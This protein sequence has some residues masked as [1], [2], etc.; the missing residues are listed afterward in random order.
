MSFLVSCSSPVDLSQ[1][2]TAAQQGSSPGPRKTFTRTRISVHA[3][4]V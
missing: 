3:C 4:T 2:Q 1:E